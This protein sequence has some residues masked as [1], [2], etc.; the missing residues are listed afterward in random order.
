MFANRF[1]QEVIGNNDGIGVDR[2]GCLIARR[3][4]KCEA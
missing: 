1:A 3:V 4:K 2:H